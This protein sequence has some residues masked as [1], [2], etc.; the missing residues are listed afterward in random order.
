MTHI[1]RYITTADIQGF[2]EVLGSVI[3]EREYLL[4]IETPSIDDIS[5]FIHNTIENDYAQYVAEV[6]GMIVGWADMIPR[7]KGSVQHTGVL[8]MGVASDYRGRGIGGDLLG[9]VIEHAWQSGLSRL[10]LE[11]LSSNHKAIAMYERHGF[12][13]EGIK[14]NAWFVDGFFKDIL[15]MA[16]YRV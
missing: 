14:H 15:I 13:H 3:K 16:Q 12:Q 11:V 8:G 6:D 5:D 1:V 10:E 9:H 4:T 7:D 2:A